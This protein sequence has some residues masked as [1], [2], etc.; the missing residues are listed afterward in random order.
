MLHSVRNLYLFLML[1]FPPI[2]KAQD[3][4]PLLRKLTVSDG[5]PQNYI[6]AIVQDSNGFIWTATRNGLARYDGRKFRSFYYT[7]SAKGG[8]SSGIITN[9]WLDKKDRLWICYESGN[10]DIFDTGTEKVIALTS[11]KEFAGLK[12]LFKKGRSFAEAGEKYWLLSITG[13]VYVIDKELGSLRHLPQKEFVQGI[14]STGNSIVL[15]TQKE[16]IFLSNTGTVTE[17]AAFPY[18][19]KIYE[20]PPAE[21]QDMSVIVRKDRKLALVDPDKVMLYSL[22]NKQFTTMPLSANEDYF[23]ADVRLLDAEGTAYF[24]LGG[25]GKLWPAAAD[26]IVDCRIGVNSSPLLID[27]SGVVW[28]GTGGLGIELFDMRV[29]HLHGQPMKERFHTD[30]LKKAGLNDKRAEQLLDTV[31]GYGWRWMYTREGTLWVAQSQADSHISSIFYLDSDKKANYPQWNFRGGEPK[32]LPTCALAEDPSGK[33][34]AVG[35]DMRLYTLNPTTNTITFKYKVP[36]DIGDPFKNDINGLIANKDDFWI[37]STMGLFHYNS[38]KG[39]TIRYF[40]D[41]RI[42]SMVSDPKNNHIL[43]I[44]TMYAGLIK[45][46]AKTRKYISYTTV[47]G[48]PNNAISN[49]I[50][51]NYGNLWGVTSK[52]LISFS[53]DGNKIRIHNARI[54]NEPMGFNRHHYFKFSD[55]RLVFWGPYGSVIFDP[56]LIL[57]DHYKPETLITSILVNNEELPANNEY[58]DNGIN[59]IDLL[60]LP[61]NKNFLTFEFAATEYNIPENLQFRYRLKGL[62]KKWIYSGNDHIATYTTLPPGNYEFLI[63]A[64]N[65]A[66]QWSDNV[67]KVRVIITPPYWRTWWFISLLFITGSLLLYY[68]IGQKIASARRKD[69]QLLSFEREAIRLEAKALRSQMNPHFIFNCLNSIKALIHTNQKKE[70]IQYLTTFAQLL[71]SQLNSNLLEISLYDELQTCELYLELESL[72]FGNKLR[73]EFILDPNVDCRD[74]KIPALL[75]QPFIENAIIHGLLPKKEGGKITVLVELRAETVVCKIDDD[76]VGRNST[77]KNEGHDSKGMKM[78]QGRLD[79]YNQLHQNNAHIEL[80]DKRDTNGMPA[81]TLVIITLFL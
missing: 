35:L 53:S 19:R 60:K 47:D 54:A 6:A 1:L 61:Y 49:I 17:R 5:L 18:E 68:G 57:Y 44:G 3:G 52:G 27:R 33:V 76:G 65:T 67:K 81:G 2:C 39:R 21:L 51:D 23:S 80:I 48:L 45:F 43:W 13:E 62:D 25:K 20:Y 72:R 41:V 40:S 73:Y 16:L 22:S 11:K 74:I 32:R 34:W 15:T 10:L 64:S 26:S 8:L 4:L 69:Q 71:R 55:G 77:L 46:N 63:N 7:P 75:V 12:G 36:I 30:I 38:G 37:S 56:R 24:M 79:L 31:S 42:L 50:F 58:S 66:G 78:V 28:G 59:G 9:M 14:A 70:A 29:S